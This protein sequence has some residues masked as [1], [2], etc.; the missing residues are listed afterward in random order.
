MTRTSRR[1]RQIPKLPNN[2]QQTFYWKGFTWGTQ[3]PLGYEESS[4]SFLKGRESYN[5][6]PLCTW[7][8]TLH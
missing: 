3:S 8:G 6:H 1:Y 2:N 4:N 7:W 5:P